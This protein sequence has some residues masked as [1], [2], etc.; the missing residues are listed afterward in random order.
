MPVSRRSAAVSSAVDPS[1]ADLDCHLR[2]YEHWRVDLSVRGPQAVGDC[3]FCGRDGKFSVEV[4]TGLWRCWS[5]GGGQSSGGGNALTFLRAYYESRRAATPPAFHAAVAADRGLLD[6]ATPAVWGA[7]QDRDGSWLLAGYGFDPE[8][9]GPRLDQLYRREWVRDKW[10]LKPTPGVWE[11]GKAHAL[12]LP[13]G[14]TDPECQTVYITEGPW[15][16]MAL[17]EA[18]RGS[19]LAPCQVIAV[20]GCTTWRDEWTEWCRGKV[21]ILLYDSDHPK[22]AWAGGPVKC[23][24]WDGMRRVVQRLSG[25]AAA[26]RVVRWGPDGYRPEAPSGWDVRDELRGATTPDGRRDAAAELVG[27]CEEAPTDWFVPVTGY[28]RNSNGNG[29]YHSTESLPCDSW[30]KCARAWDAGQGGALLWRRDLSDALAVML[31]VCASTKQ[32]GNQLFLDLIGS[33]GSAKTTLCRGLLVSH[34]CIHLENVSKLVSGFRKKDD[35][36]KDCSFIA[37]ANNKTWVTCEFDTLG[38][39][40]QYHELMGKARRIFDGETSTT[41][42]NRD[43]DRVYQALRTPWIRA[44]TPKMMD[45]DQSQLGDRFVRFILSDPPGQERRAIALAAMRS[46]RAAMVD[47]A[48]ATAGSLVDAKTRLAHALTGGYVDWLRS[49]VEDELVRVDIPDAAEEHFIDLAELSADLR[50]RPGDD[51][52]KIE[53]RSSKELPT[54]LARQNIRLACCLAVVL[55]KRVVDAEVV[56]IVRHVALDT[57]HGHSLDVVRWLCTPNPRGGGRTYQETG[58][59]ATETLAFWLGTTAERALKLCMFLQRPEIAVLD[60][61]RAGQSSGGGWVLTDRVLDLYLRVVGG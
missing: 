42:G 53:L 9:R 16:G 14:D 57:A 8:T 32:S 3:P 45:H 15:D 35:P 33:P 36:E 38:T 21:V 49:H 1:S 17:W 25:V 11:P 10:V 51:K 23:A 61:S 26:V 27:T 12:H 48:N 37:R 4:E 44:G 7:A 22:E 54:R 29:Y 43:E 6:L 39:S 31:A 19:A 34:H 24:G 5:C 50:A 40:P 60:W 13:A 28:H 41:Y 18:A 58:G 30:A 52:H 56:R 55:N 2:P 59:L 20:P 46:E 47:V